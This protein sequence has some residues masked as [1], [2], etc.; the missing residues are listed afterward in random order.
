MLQRVL[1]FTVNA[2]MSQSDEHPADVADKRAIE[3]LAYRLTQIERLCVTADRG[4]VVWDATPP[5]GISSEEHKLSF[6]DAI[7]MGLTFCGTLL[8]DEWLLVGPNQLGLVRTL[9]AFEHSTG[10]NI[11]HAM[12]I[13][14]LHDIVSV[15]F[16]FKIASNQFWMG[17][18]D[19]AAQ[20]EVRNNT[21]FTREGYHNVP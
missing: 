2:V 11:G 15:Y 20:G 6:V 18:T 19:R 12:R 3:R 16:S 10:E 13:G 7:M 9:P 5:V 4:F 17:T 21:S 14:T 8:R 1:S